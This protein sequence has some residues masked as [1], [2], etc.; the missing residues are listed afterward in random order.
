MESRITT[1][2]VHAYGVVRVPGL[3]REARESAMDLD[4]RAPGRRARHQPAV[5]VIFL[6]A[7]LATF[8]R[9]SRRTPR[10]S[11][12]SILVWSITSESVNCR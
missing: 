4:S 6:G 2:A 1:A 5:M 3:Q 11:L 10:L 8:G 12:A 9:L 7:A